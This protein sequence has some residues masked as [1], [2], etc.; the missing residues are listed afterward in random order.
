MEKVRHELTDDADQMQ[1]SINTF[2]EHELEE[3]EWEKVRDYVNGGKVHWI[4]E[5]GSYKARRDPFPSIVNN[6]VVAGHNLALST[7]LITQSNSDFF[8]IYRNAVAEVEH[9]LNV[10]MV[11]L[12]DVENHM[13][14]SIFERI[15]YISIACMVAVSILYVALII[16][17]VLKVEK[18]NYLSWNVLLAIPCEYIFDLM[19][20]ITDRLYE[21]HGIESFE[22]E[23]ANL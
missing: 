17:F 6:I 13:A 22:M 20:I 10:T 4:Y 14:D 18:E 7:E 9:T 11:Y 5:N 21:V 3:V 23:S 12:V 1:S 15:L 2:A 16:P 8:Y 19:R